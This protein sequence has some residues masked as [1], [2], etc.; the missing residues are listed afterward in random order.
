MFTK[1]RTK[2]KIRYVDI[3]PAPNEQKN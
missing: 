3:Y 2:N 1:I